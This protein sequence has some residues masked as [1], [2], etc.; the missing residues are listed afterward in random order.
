MI[1]EKKKF[2]FPKPEVKTVKLGDQEVIVEPFLD[3][4]AQKVILGVYLEQ[5]FEGG[6]YAVMDA[7][8]SLILG[9]L[10]YSTN[11]MT[12]EEV[13]GKN[14]AVINLD[15]L[16]RNT[17]F[18]REVLGSIENY[19][20]FRDKIDATVSFL[21]AERNTLGNKLEGLYNRAV[22][23]FSEMSDMSPEKMDSIKTQLQELQNS[24]IIKELIKQGKS[25]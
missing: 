1:E 16:F 18:I 3:E 24:P 7:E 11:V 22:E 14:T 23:F 4:N 19:R 13:D 12:A 9:I 21:Q 5:L 20:E 25:E 17:K 10:E 15:M 2:V 6:N 8:N